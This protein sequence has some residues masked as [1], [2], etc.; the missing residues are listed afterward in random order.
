MSK[1]EFPGLDR[2]IESVLRENL[3]TKPIPAAPNWAAAEKHGALRAPE[4]PIDSAHN[5]LE[6]ARRVATR[7]ATLRDRLVGPVPESAGK[8]GA[9]TGG[10]GVLGALHAHAVDVADEL[11]VAAQALS[12]IERVLP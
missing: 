10:S 11:S 3:G 1:D 2:G 4:G 12:D 5:T 8:V 9:D 7:V 6:L